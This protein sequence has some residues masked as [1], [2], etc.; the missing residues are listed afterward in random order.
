MIIYGP[1]PSRRL[2][3]S[4]GINNIPPK[5]CSYSCAYCQQGH[6]FK[7]QSE[8]QL[9]YPASQIF[10]E[11]RIKVEQ[12]TADN[13]TIDYLSFVPD[14]EPTLDLALGEEIEMLKALGKVAVITNASLIWR[15]DVR[16][17][18]GKADWV[19]LKVDAV[20]EDIW[21]RIDHPLKRLS[22]DSILDGILNF[23]DSFSGKLVTETMLVKGINDSEECLN[24]IASF[25][26][27]FTPSIAYLAIPTRPPADKRVQAPDEYTINKAFQIF[28]S[29]IS[30][31]EYLIGYEGNDFSFSGDL[32][33]DILSITSVH[34][35]REDA[36]QEFLD[37]SGASWEAIKELIKEQKLLE[38]SFQGNKYYMR[39]LV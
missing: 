7:M 31:T 10:S 37:K 16:S 35:M 13:E 20:D 3:R 23:A 28:N 5:I 32:E 12:A 24:N 1:V 8:R 34:P 15:E 19:S 21:R 30:Q 6:S 18:L 39:K 27:K 36:V 29:H 17:E 25:L 14:G 4:L 2:G 9:F 22:L 11:A 26:H 38:L 33:E